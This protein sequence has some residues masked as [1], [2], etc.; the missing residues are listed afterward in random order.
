MGKT[1]LDIMKQSS[2]NYIRKIEDNVV[3]L[4]EAARNGDAGT[5]D[6]LVKNG[7]SPLMTLHTKI[8]AMHVH[9]DKDVEFVSLEDVIQENSHLAIFIAAGFG[10]ADAIRPLLKV[11]GK[12]QLR[13]T[14]TTITNYKRLKY[15]PLE[16]AAIS[17]SSDAV[18][19]ILTN[20][21]KAFPVFN[22]GEP[23][24]RQYHIEPIP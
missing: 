21:P 8:E 1:L 14:I 4:L 19:W 15:S 12:Q 5:I 10:H 3:Q 24:Q 16:L 6:N 20:Y 23:I 9:E 22:L 18:D 7:I 11:E 13:S 2:D 17:G